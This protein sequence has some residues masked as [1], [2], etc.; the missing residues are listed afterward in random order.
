MRNIEITCPECR[1][2]VFVQIKFLNADGI[3]I[4]G[5]GVNGN[6]KH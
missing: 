3:E 4:N 2:T 5:R 1:K 6:G